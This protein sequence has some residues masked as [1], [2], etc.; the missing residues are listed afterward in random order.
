MH[1]NK[2]LAAVAATVVLGA[3]LGGVASAEKA[4]KEEGP[5]KEAAKLQTMTKEPHGKFL[6][7]G[8]GRAVY[9][10]EKDKGAKG[11]TCSDACAKAWPPVLAGGNPA[12]LAP[13][14]DKNKLGTIE[15][16]DGARQLTY[17]GWPLYYFVK[18]QAKGDT[19]GQ[20]VKGF[21]AE[22]YLIG[23]DG[24]KVHE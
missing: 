5:G 17:G 8:E 20:D 14:L 13:A 22:W 19:K 11:S 2:A 4:P 6:T 21:G 15:R 10:F 7:D 24:K 3:G 1:T 16:P 18:D 9:L 12:E 23:P